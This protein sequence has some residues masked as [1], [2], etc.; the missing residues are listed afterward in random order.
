MFDIQSKGI[1]PVVKTI[2]DYD[3]YIRPFSAFLA[4]NIS[5]EL[6]ATLSP[7][8]GTLVSFF[9]EAGK[10]GDEITANSIMDMDLSGSAITVVQ[11]FK[12]V[13]GAKL[14]K[15]LRTLLCAHRNIAFAPAGTS[16]GEIETLDASYIDKVFTG[17]IENMF[18]LALEVIKV[19]YSGFF[20]KLSSRSGGA[21]E[22]LRAKKV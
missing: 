6:I 15:L 4:S 22:L 7:V 20:K 5:G 10:S 13:D 3:Y 21:A 2:G 16:E 14:E 9:D 19:N 12:S 8:L 1:E 17:E 18:L 11:A